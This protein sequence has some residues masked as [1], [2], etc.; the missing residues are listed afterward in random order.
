MGRP[1]VLVY[2]GAH[3]GATLNTIYY[4]FD[5]VYAFEPDPLVFSYLSA[6]FAAAPNVE[7]INAACAE[8]D[9][10][11]KFHLFNIRQSSSLSEGNRDYLQED[12]DSITV[13]TINLMRFL[14]DKGVEYIDMYQSD[15]QGADLMVL[16]TIED[17]VRSK[18]IGMMEIETNWDGERLYTAF[19]NSFNSFKEFLEPDY[20][21]SHAFI[22][23]PARHEYARIENIN[24]YH[25]MEW[26]TV[27]L[28]TEE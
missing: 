10:E 14:N 2:V 25:S 17:F 19:D 27:W 7:L 24:D 23:G 28:P 5:M 18:R 11:A 15:I 4:N 21:P 22:G 8:E 13:K 1:S 9:G 16:R 6:N 26:D 20:Y 3:C 12:E